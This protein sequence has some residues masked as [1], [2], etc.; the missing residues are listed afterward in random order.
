MKTLQF[1]LLFLSLT[2][3]LSAQNLASDVDVETDDN[4]ETIVR[5]RPKRVDKH[6][7]RI[8]VGSY[9]M[10]ADAFLDGIGCWD[11][12]DPD[13]RESIIKSDSYLTERRFVGVYS[14][15]YAYHFRRGFQFGVTAS[16]GVATQARRDNITNKRVEDLNQY[17]VSV[18]PSARFIY[19]YREHVQLYSTVSLGVIV[20]TNFG[21]SW[22]DFALFGCS[23]G[24][25]LF[26]FAEIGAGFGGWGRI[27]IGYR[28]DA[29][30]KGKK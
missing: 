21:G 8:G 2:G 27:G 7:F 10:A 29:K 3:T 22:P 17:F 12:S 30:K 6:E 18:T 14:L 28:F 9:S 5:K 15:G 19:L 20:G 13:F 16:F 25:D 11:Y 24:R 4:I 1:L 26:G 23:F